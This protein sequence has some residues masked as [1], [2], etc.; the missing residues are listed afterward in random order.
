[1]TKRT[2]HLTEREL[3]LV[4]DALPFAWALLVKDEPE[5]AA[6]VKEKICDLPGDDSR[7]RAKTLALDRLTRDERDAFVKALLKALDRLG[8]GKR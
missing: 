1:M 6:S 7:A 4:E 2:S 8:S 3:Q 5:I